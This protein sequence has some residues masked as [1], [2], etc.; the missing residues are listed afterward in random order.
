MT[1][2]W[3]TILLLFIRKKNCF[4][5]ETSAAA[6]PQFVYLQQNNPHKVN[7]LLNYT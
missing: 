4:K 5:I 2:E 1:F 7:L 3:N 6:V